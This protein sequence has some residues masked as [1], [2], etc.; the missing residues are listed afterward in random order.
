M[1]ENFR[2]EYEEEITEDG[3]D[4][5]LE[6]LCSARFID[7]KIDLITKAN[8]LAGDN[9]IRLLHL[10][11]TLISMFGQSIGNGTNVVLHLHNS[12]GNEVDIII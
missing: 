2:D 3:C 4:S 11:K 12:R 9:T 10:R 6:K 7:E 8:Q 1:S 5:Y